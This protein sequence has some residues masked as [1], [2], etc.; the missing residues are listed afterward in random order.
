MYPD[1]GGLNIAGITRERLAECLTWLRKQRKPSG[2]APRFSER[3]IKHTLTP[4]GQVFDYAIRQG[5]A[6]RNPV[7]ELDRDER[8]KPDDETEKRILSE[9]EIPRLIAAA[10]PTYRPLIQAALFTGGRKMELLGLTWADVEFNAQKIRVRQQLSRKP[11][12]GRKALKTKAKG[13]HDVHIP[14]FLVQMLREH[15]A[16]S[17]FSKDSDYVFTTGSGK[18]FGWSNVDRQGLRKACERAKLR[19]PYPTFHQLR[20]TFVSILIAQGRPVPYVANQIGDSVETTLRTYAH[21]FG[22]AAHADESRAAMEAAF[23]NSVVTA[24]SEAPEMAREAAVV[25]IA[26]KQGKG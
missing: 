26:S 7:R 6:F 10:S 2:A 3:T 25:N 22:E 19:E 11:G 12:A 5:M 20:H 8:P 16:G 24:G 13:Q 9:E 14:P 18:P 1:I 17:P 21:L 15:K 4:V 23:G